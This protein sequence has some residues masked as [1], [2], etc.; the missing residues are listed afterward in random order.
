MEESFVIFVIYVDDIIIMGNDVKKIEETKMFLD[1]KFSIK[2]LRT[3]KY[4]LGIEVTHT[5]KGMVLNQ[6]KYTLDSLEDNDML[7]C[8]PSAFPM[9]QNMKLGKTDEECFV[10]VSKYRRLI[11]SLLYLQTT[12]P[13]ITYSVNVL[14]QFV[15]DLRESYMEAVKRVLRYLK[16]M[17]GLGILLLKEGGTNLVTYTES[18]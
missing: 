8:R 1:T 16:A 11:G 10:D 18:D 9:E 7:G 6:R 3:L 2:D 15:A 17:P 14:S 5:R 13:N 4:F 12:R